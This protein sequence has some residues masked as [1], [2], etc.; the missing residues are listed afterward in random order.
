[1]G[2]IELQRQFNVPIYAAMLEEVRGQKDAL[3]NAIVHRRSVDPGASLTE[4]NAWH[5]SGHLFDD[6][7]DRDRADDEALEL[8]RTVI[9]AVARGALAPHYATRATWEPTLTAAWAVI[10]G[11]NGAHVPHNHA[12]AAWSG[13]VYV[14]V[15]A[16]LEGRRDM[17]AGCIEFLSPIAAANAFFMP[18]GA[19]YTPRDGLGLLF[20]GPLVHLVHP[21]EGEALR[22]CVSF[23][24]DVR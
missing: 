5:S 2:T 24:I 14:D 22:I 18:S 23:N 9:L 21:S 1:M 8:L 3:R 4:R 16:S 19:V 17:R 12:P 7:L 10:G 6:R 20:P 13:V 11:L 15:E